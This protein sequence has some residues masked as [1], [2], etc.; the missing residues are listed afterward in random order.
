[1]ECKLYV[2]ESLEQD[3]YDNNFIISNKT[4]RFC[5]VNQLLAYAETVVMA[6]EKQKLR[7]ACQLSCFVSNHFR[8]ILHFSPFLLD[9][10]QVS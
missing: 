4:K 3:A 6:R 1:M 2:V 7:R 8:M 9:E 10:S 5:G